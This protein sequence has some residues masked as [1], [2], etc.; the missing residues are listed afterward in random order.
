[1]RLPDSFA[2]WVIDDDETW[3][4]VVETA[5]SRAG[6]NVQSFAS[7][8]AFKSA[9]ETA[10][11]GCM[12]ADLHIGADDGLALIEHV[13]ASSWPAPAILLSGN[14][15]PRLTARAMR[16][17]VAMAIEKPVAMP[18]LIQE[19]TAAMRQ[20]ESLVAHFTRQEAARQALQRLS[21]GQRDVLRELLACR[22]HKQIASQL[23]IALRTVEKRKREI[24]EK[25][26]VD[27]FAELLSLVQLANFRQPTYPPFTYSLN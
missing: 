16:A 10:S 9:L 11:P 6:W 23:D 19:T 24:F 21:E 1:M 26:S 5:L 4:S 14:L 15:S 7:A 8:A 25:L 20:A 27:T 18:D 12:I 3:L 13:H 22:P 2:L 17:G